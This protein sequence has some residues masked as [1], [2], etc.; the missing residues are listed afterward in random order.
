[1]ILV[2][3]GF[4]Y[5]L[6][7][8]D[9]AWHARAVAAA[10]AIEE[11]WVTTWPVLTEAVHLA[12]RWLGVSAAIALVQEV[13]GGDIHAWDLSPMALAKL[14]ALLKRYADLPMDLA[15]A[16]LVLLAESLG[17]GRILTTDE[18]DFRTYRWKSRAPFE[19]LLANF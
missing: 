7:D 13:A 1:M 8:K 5:A 19:N 15:D 14:P 6:L 4:L 3:T 11:G 17:H 18:R 12:T 10:D 9:D 16:S 2:D